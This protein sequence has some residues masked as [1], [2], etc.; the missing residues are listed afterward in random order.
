MFC[1]NLCDIFSM[2][3]TEEYIEMCAVKIE[4]M[5]KKKIERIYLG[6]YFCDQF[7][8]KFKGYK[9]LLQYCKVKKY[10][11]HLLFRYLVKIHCAEGKKEYLRYVEIMKA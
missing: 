9:Q 2:N 4:G 6:S 3:E 1:I 5:T 11:R 8:L 10:M 7:F